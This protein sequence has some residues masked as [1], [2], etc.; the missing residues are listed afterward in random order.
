M[1]P[2]WNVDDV[3]KPQAAPA[4]EYA[5][6]QPIVQLYKYKYK[7]KNKFE[8]KWKNVVPLFLIVYIQLQNKAFKQWWQLNILKI[9]LPG[10]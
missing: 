1:C 7:H 3:K 6:A 2:A 10:G 4:V 8:C 9:I 5:T